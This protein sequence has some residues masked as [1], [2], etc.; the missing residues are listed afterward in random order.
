M[1]GFERIIERFD[2]VAL[3]V[4][5]IRATLPLVRLMGGEFV[6]GADHPRN[7]FRWVQFDLPGPSRLELIQPLSEES[8]LT[9]YLEGRGEG[10]HHI[11][12]KVADVSV[13]ARRA[14]ELGYKT[15]GLHVHP[16]WSE[17]FLHPKTAHGTLI[18]MAAWPNDSA[19][20]GPSLED[21]LG[22]LALDP[23]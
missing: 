11:T 6:H 15:T 22:G 1:E 21:V 9:R 20:R 4:N 7:K 19:W 5:D 8:F 12:F 18:Q 14:E 23:T 10:F 13:A 16:D 3:A 2:H 17:V